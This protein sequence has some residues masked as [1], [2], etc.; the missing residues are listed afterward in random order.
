[1]NMFSLQSFFA[2]FLRYFLFVYIISG[3][4]EKAM[5]QPAVYSRYFYCRPRLSGQ[6]CIGD[7]NR[8]AA[9][10]SGNSFVCETV[11]SAVSVLTLRMNVFFRK[12]EDK[13]K[14]ACPRPFTL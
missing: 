1:M 14:I 4:K 11:Y 10:Q 8:Q 5:L 9:L 13:P 3:N 12:K 6:H 2:G 7:V